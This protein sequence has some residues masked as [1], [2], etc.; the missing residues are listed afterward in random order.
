MVVEK[1]GWDSW[2]AKDSKGLDETLAKDFAF[3]DAM[4]KAT[5]NRADALKGWTTDNPCNV[6]SVSLSDAQSQSL[7]ATVAIL[8]VKGTAVGTCGDAKL[9]PLWN[10]TVFV[11]EGDMWKA[12][13]IFETPTKK[14]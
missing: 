4:G 14:M 9:E 6:S 12:A 3:V 13:Y 10:T 7:S 2:K 8:V 1:K 5:L 11:K